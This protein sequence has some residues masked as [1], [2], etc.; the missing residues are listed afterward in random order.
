MKIFRAVLVS[1]SL[2]K[3]SLNFDAVNEDRVIKLSDVR[4]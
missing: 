2:A 1:L 4:D 3:N